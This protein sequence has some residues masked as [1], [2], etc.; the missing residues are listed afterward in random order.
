MHK[1]HKR[2]FRKTNESKPS[3]M[4]SLPRAKSKE[5]R[6][7]SKEQRAKSKEQSKHKKMGCEQYEMLGAQAFQ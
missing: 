7:K 5:Q 2:R 3:M 1:L 4:R 6:A